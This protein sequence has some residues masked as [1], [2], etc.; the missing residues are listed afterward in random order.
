[1]RKGSWVP[2][3][4]LGGYSLILAG[5]ELHAGQGAVKPLLAEI[6]GD[7]FFYGVNTTISVFLIWGSAL[8]FAACMLC[9]KADEDRRERIFLVSQVVFFFYVGFDDRFKMHEL[10][11]QKTEVNDAVFVIGLGLVELF[12]LA[13]LGDLR[14]RPRPAKAFLLAAASAFGL[15]V[16]LDGLAPT[17]MLLQLTLQDV[18][19]TWACLFLFLFAWEIC[20]AK[21]AVLQGRTGGR[22]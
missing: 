13:R 5:T 22:P 12:L 9:T 7:A 19:K 20:R 18:S 11:Y 15:M 4:L 10:L 1:M 17:G 3:I 8:L 14:S 21:A 6:E 16:A 2:F